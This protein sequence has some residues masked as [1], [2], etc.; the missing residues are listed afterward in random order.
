MYI[1]IHTVQLGVPAS[2]PYICT[3]EY[4]LHMR[5]GDVLAAYEGE[6]RGTQWA[7]SG[8]YIGAQW[9]F[10]QQSCRCNHPVGRSYTSTRIFR[11]WF[12]MTS[13]RQ[14]YFIAILTK[15]MCFNMT[16]SRQTHFIDILTKALWFNMTISRQTHFIDILTKAMCFNMTISRQTHFIAILTKAMC[17]NMTISRQTFIL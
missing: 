13:S 16:I 12:N 3:R 9:A 4:K 8:G 11:C 6:G 7:A 10:C 5:G 15:V 14:T 17:F 2:I 1:H